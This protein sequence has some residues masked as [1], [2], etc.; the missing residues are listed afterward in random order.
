MSRDFIYIYMCAQSQITPQF[1]NALPRCIYISGQ[2]VVVCPSEWN[3]SVPT[4][5]SFM[6]FDI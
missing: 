6:K 3:S 4:E 5:Q 2:S 1:H